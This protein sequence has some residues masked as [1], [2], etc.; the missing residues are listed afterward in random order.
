MLKIAMLGA[1][2]ISDSHI[3]AYLKY[4]DRCQITAIVDLYPEK[5][6]EKAARHGLSIPAFK[7]VEALLRGADFDAASVCLP[8]FEH[9]PAAVALLRA[10]KHVLVEKPMATCL[11]EC[12]AM[13]EA[14]ALGGKQ[15]SVVAQNR[16][17]TPMMKLK[18]I[19]ESGILGKV[20]HAQVDSYWWR[21]GNYY[22]LWWRGTWAREGGGC[23]MNHAV[24]HID[25]F[26]W[27]MGMPE[28]VQAWSANLAHD[29]SEVEDFST[30]ML[31]YRNGAI[32]QITASL[33][34]HGEE[35]QL[36]FQ[37][38]KARVAV[39]WS[40]RAMKQ[41]ENGFPE[42]DSEVQAGAQAFY[43]QLPALALEGHDGQIDNFLAAINGREPL[44]VDGRQGRQTLELITAI[45]QSSHLGGSVKLPLEKHAPFYSR[46]GI[47]KQ[48]LHFHE[49][50]KSVENFASNDITLGRALGK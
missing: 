12:D 1:G 36:A 15:L 7:D 46:D 16:F 19:L 29:N 38:D 37:T 27:M 33:V 50:T 5:A 44:L 47:L 2:A 28:E 34:H 42:D 14:A 22:D 8:P 39:P 32:G 9:A 3:Q 25:I 17:K 11:E 10:G 30:A 6:A 48:A 23:T 45:Y 13:M 40:V 35:Q 41:K 24:H 26:Q 43:D 31:R 4:A 20:L 21:G 49:K 18:R